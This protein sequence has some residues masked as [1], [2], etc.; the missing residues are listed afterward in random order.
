LSVY[1]LSDGRATCF[2]WDETGRLWLLWDSH[3]LDYLF[4]VVIIYCSSCLLLFRLLHWSES[5]HGITNQTDQMWT[6][7]TIERPWNI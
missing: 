7:G 2:M 6:F 1:S 5:K 3:L 4:E